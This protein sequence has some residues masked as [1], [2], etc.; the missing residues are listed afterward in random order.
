MRTFDVEFN[1]G[2]VS[3]RVKAKSEREAIDKANDIRVNEDG[4][5]SPRSE[6]TEINEVK[7]K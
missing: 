7:V 5:I 1:L 4:Y 3:Y 2:F 6:L